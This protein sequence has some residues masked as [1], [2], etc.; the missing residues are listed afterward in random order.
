MIKLK[1]KKA[2]V[3]VVLFVVGVFFICSF[4]FLTFFISDF[5]FSNSFV[6]VDSMRQLNYQYD[7]YLYH[8]NQGVTYA[9]LE[10]SFNISEDDLGKHFLV[11]NFQTKT[12]VSLNF[13]W[14]QKELLFSVK[15]YLP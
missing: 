10:N 14:R 1:N 7:E 6:G 9:R 5:K 3:P 13:P 15:Y 8:V 2:S 11:E 4:A 12:K